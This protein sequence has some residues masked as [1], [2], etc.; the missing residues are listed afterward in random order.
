MTVATNL[1]THF[2]S[3]ELFELS[4]FILL[5][6]APIIYISLLVLAHKRKTGNYN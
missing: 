2:T 5:E 1:F 4:N 6:L 3:T